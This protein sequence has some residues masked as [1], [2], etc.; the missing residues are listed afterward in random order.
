MTSLTSLLEDIEEEVVVEEGLL[1][2]IL[3]EVEEEK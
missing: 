3:A 1:A 2:M